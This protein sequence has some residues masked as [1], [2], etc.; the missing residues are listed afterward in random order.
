MK[1]QF[2]VIVMIFMGFISLSGY[3]INNPTLRNFVDKDANQWYMIIAGFAAFLGVINLLQLHS[4]KIIYK[5]KNWQYSMLTLIGFLLMIFFGFVLFRGARVLELLLERIACLGSLGEIFVDCHPQHASEGSQHKPTQQHRREG[6]HEPGQVAPRE[7]GPIVIRSQ[8]RINLGL[9]ANHLHQGH[10][11]LVIRIVDGPHGKRVGNPL[12]T[13]QDRQVGSHQEDSKQG[14]H[15][16]LNADQRHEGDNHPQINGDD[17]F[18][19]T[20]RPQV[21]SL[22]RG[23]AEPLENRVSM[24]G[25][26]TW[27][28]L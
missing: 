24:H 28:R 26:T 16:H 2:A 14:N 20:E 22:F 11:D 3:F 17:H 5:K 21:G 15:E 4:K 13:K 12:Q 10:A 27:Q 18:A 6:I 7:M 9:E 1:K 25:G 19:R 23:C 8:D